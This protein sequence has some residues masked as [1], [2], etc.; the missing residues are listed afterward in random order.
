MFLPGKVLHLAKTETVYKGCGVSRERKF[1]PMWVEDRG[2]FNEIQINQWLLFDHF[3]NYNGVVI[4]KTLKEA[5]QAEGR[6]SFGGGG[7]LD[8]TN[9]KLEV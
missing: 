1:A 9:P 8:A 2:D 6:I 7:L 5:L 4:Q 3:P